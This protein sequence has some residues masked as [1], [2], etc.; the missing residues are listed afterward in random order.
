MSRKGWKL[1]V[2]IANLSDLIHFRKRKLEELKGCLLKPV[3]T[4][5]AFTIFTSVPSN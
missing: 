5:M 2:F 4:K 3:F 1:H